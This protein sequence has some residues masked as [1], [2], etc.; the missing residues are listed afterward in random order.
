[1]PFG[2]EYEVRV[3]RHDS[4]TLKA[5]PL[6]FA[7]DLPYEDQRA[8]REVVGKRIIFNGYDEEGRAELE[9][10]DGNGV[11]RTIW[12]DPKFIEPHDSDE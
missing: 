8:L 2:E 12:L 9:F 4:V 3:R 11:N 1:M 6:R 7:D 10:T 5:S